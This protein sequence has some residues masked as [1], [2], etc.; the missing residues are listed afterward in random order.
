M[1]FR[2]LTVCF[3]VGSIICT[4]ALPA[5]LDAASDDPAQGTVWDLSP[6]YRDAGAWDKERADVEAL[7]PALLRLKGGFGA[8]AEALRT[9]LDELSGVRQR[10]NRLDE[11]ASLGAAEDAS[12][13]ASQER[14]QAISTLRARFDEATSF[15]QPE[16]LALGRDRVEGFE[17]ADPGLSR[18]RRQ[19]ELILRRA[20][21][22]LGPEA[23]T[24]V[25]ATRPLREQPGTIHDI[26]LYS[27]IPWPSL[28]ID[29]KAILLEPE[30]YRATLFN[31]ERETRRKAFESVTATLARYERT[32]GAVAFGFLAGTAFE[33]KARHYPSSLALALSDDAMPEAGF[34]TLVAEADRA[35]PTLHRYI[36]LRKKI[37]GLDEM[38]VYDLRVPLTVNAHR[39]RLDEGEALI[40]KALAPL[41]EDYVHTLNKD[42]QSHAMH[43][44]AHRGKTPGAFTYFEAYG[45]QPFVMV[46][47]DG[48][49]DSV[50]AVAHE[51]GHAVH[52]QLF[53]AAQPF[54]NADITSTFLFD[55]P[56]LTNEILLSDYMIAHAKTRQDKI[57]ALDQAID[58][59]RSSYFAVLVDVGF[60]IKA[61]E[62]ADRGEAVTGRA[63]NDIYC[64]LLK[65]FNGADDGV[66]K[67]DEY[68]CSGWV[69]RPGIYYDFYFYKY[70][71]AVSVA[72]F[73]AD[74]LE[75]RDVD[76]RKRYFDL[77]K[78]GGSDD[79]H[80]LLKRAG[81]DAT[82]PA[83]YQPMVR[84]L[85]RLVAE[86]EAVVAQ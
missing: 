3:A 34:Q 11:Y 63:L 55:T 73:F 46:T 69:N 29:G 23:E 47:F 56:S 26:L 37:L 7:L 33:A 19:L 57:L 21:H 68:T 78:A 48:S 36:K 38:H 30:A 58:L 13:D 85:E 31:S 76:T 10:L 5:S 8:S 22:T 50:G 83:A 18:H 67:F 35:L 45:V 82:S 28:E 41:G 27:D 75:K 20:A 4:P 25:A 81:F 40:L 1:A 42:F 14:V 65:R 80:V 54:E 15:V 77:L 32:A 70:L 39:Y 17:S 72:A 49:Y 12:I 61:H 24:V 62:V 59:L 71:T 74:G 52:G 9:G 44:I 51:W 53:Q 64:G 43:A 86:L 60:E 84:R 16:I 6:L 2:A 79:P 66:T